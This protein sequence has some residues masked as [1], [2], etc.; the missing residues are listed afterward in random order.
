MVAEWLMTLAA[1]GGSALVGAAATSAW[2]A[3]RAGIAGLFGR[4]GARRAEL[5]G[6]WADETAAALAQAPADQ[7]AVVRDQSARAWQQRLVDLVR[8]Y[9]EVVDELRSWVEQTKRD[10]PEPRQGW[11]NTF[12]ARDNAT[13]YNAPGGSIVVNNTDGGTAD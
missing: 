13:Q 12:V 5:V 11:V 6:Q 10:L 8:E 7:L 1:T 2:E 3:A 9:P 4:A